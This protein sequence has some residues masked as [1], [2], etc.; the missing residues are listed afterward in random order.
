MLTDDTDTTSL[1]CIAQLLVPNSDQFKRPGF[2]D[3]DHLFHAALFCDQYSEY[4][5]RPGRYLAHFSLRTLPDVASTMRRRKLEFAAW[6]TSACAVPP[7]LVTAT[8]RLSTCFGSLFLAVAWTRCDD[9]VWP[10][11]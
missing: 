10:N 11:L 8:S 1:T 6:Q 7:G 5:L 9:L 4:G 2:H 3:Y